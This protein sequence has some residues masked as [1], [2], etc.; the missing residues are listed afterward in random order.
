MVQGSQP[1]QPLVVQNNARAFNQPAPSGCNT[2]QGSQPAQPLRVQMAQGFFALL[3]HCVSSPCSSITEVPR[4]ISHSALRFSVVCSFFCRF[5]ALWFIALGFLSAPSALCGSSPCSIT[6]FHRHVA[7][8]LWFYA[9][10]PSAPCDSVFCV[11]S[12]AGSV[13]FGSSSLDLFQR[14]AVQCS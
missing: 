4:W 6:A 9:E 7:R 5:S 13:L 8:S 3:D 2:V 10:S 14:P 12:S 1:A 11:Y